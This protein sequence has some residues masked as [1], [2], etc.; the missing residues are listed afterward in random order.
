MELPINKLGPSQVTSHIHTGHVLSLTS[1]TWTTTGVISSYH[2]TLVD[3]FSSLIMAENFQSPSM[4]GTPNPLHLSFPVVNSTG[5]L[6]NFSRVS[7]PAIGSAWLLPSTSGV[8]FPPLMG[9]TYLYQH[10]ST[11]ILSGVPGQ[12]HLSTPAT[13]SYPGI[14]EWDV[15]GSSGEKPSLGDFTMT[16]TGQ[17]TPT[18]SIPAPAQY[19]KAA[20]AN[21]VVPLYPQLSASL[22]QQ[23][24]S[25]QMPSQV[26]NNV[27]VHYQNGSQ[28]YHY[29]Q[30]TLGPLLAGELSPCVQSYGTVSYK[31]GRTPSVPVASQPEMVMVLKEVHPPGSRPPVSTSGLYYPVCAQSVK[32]SGFQVMETSLGLQPTARTSSLPQTLELSKS[33][34]SNGSNVQILEGTPP[35]EVAPDSSLATPAQ[36]SGNLLA[37]PPAPNIEHKDKKN[38]ACLEKEK[39]K[40]EG[41]KAKF[42]QSL[43]AC[44]VPLEIQDLPLPPLE[45][46]DINQLLACIDPLCPDAL[47]EG[48]SPR[49]CHLVRNGLSLGDQ[50][51][52]ENG[53][54]SI[55]SLTDINKLV[56]DFRLPRLLS[57]LKEVDQPKGLRATKPKVVKTAK[58]V[59]VQGKSCTGKE[60]SDPTKKTKRKVPELIATVPPAKALPRKPDCLLAGDISGASDSMANELSP[61][62]MAKSTSSKSRKAPSSRTIKA[63]GPSREKMEGIGD[64]SYEKVEGN[65]PPGGRAKPEKP[66]L[67]KMKR[68]KNHPELNQEAFKKPRSFLGMHMLE[69]VQVFHALGKKNDKMAGQVQVPQPTP[70]IKQWLETPAEGHSP[71]KNQISLLAAA[72]A[73]VWKPEGSAENQCPSPSHTKPPPLGKVRLVPLPFPTLDRPLTRPIPRKPQPLAPHRLFT[74][75]PARLGNPDQPGPSNPARPVS[76][77]PPKS[78][79]PRPMLLKS[80]PCPSP[81]LQPC[82]PSH[83]VLSISPDSATTSSS[84]QAVVIMTQPQPQAQF[85]PQDFCFQPIPWRKPNVPEPVMSKPI[86]KEQRPEREAMKRQAQWERENAAKYTSLGKLQFFIEREKDLEIARHYGY[87][88]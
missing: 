49:E 46:P 86:T 73:K 35:A 36:N 14:Y 19:D 57:P 79:P 78:A 41:V 76:A 32:D 12:G 62:D 52:L 7:A 63:K 65:E 67:P 82:L 27:S 53:M 9:N 85:Q 44:H 84:K 88:I 81:Q 39:W 17:D 47:K 40:V 64:T 72:K 6:C 80:V 33:W 25:P 42:F 26:P 69:S 24:A 21:T 8:P 75:N 77:V 83:L 2:L 28:V 16:V 3:V 10:S 58:V 87:M 5:N 61:L 50:E 54:E 74:T 1:V 13:S 29:N 30:G 38:V 20:G 15:S 60:P 43:E 48:T 71:M 51:T 4:L 59:R 45:I 11:T 22:V 34:G 55:P 70:G 18:S 31:G 68:K 66:A 37:L 56:E 23:G